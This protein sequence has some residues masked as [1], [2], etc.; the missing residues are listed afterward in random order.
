MGQRPFVWLTSALALTIF[1]L[2]N[3]LVQ[4]ALSGWRADFTEGK[5]FTL[6]DGTR[7]TLTDL[8]EPVELTFIYSRRVGQEFPA[9]RAYAQRVREL[10]QS[11]EAEAG[12]NLRLVE[13]DPTPFSEA[14]DEALSNGITAVQTDGDDP[15]YFG[16]VGR[17]AVD[18]DLV[19]PYLAPEREGTLEYDLTRLIARLDNPDPATIGILTDLPNFEG[20]GSEGGYFALQ[21]IARSYDIETIGSNF[22]SLP[23]RVDILLMAHVTDLSDEQ[24]YLIDQFLLDKGRALILVD[25]ASKAAAASGLVGEDG[26]ARSDLGALGEAW[27]LRLSQNAVADAPHALPVTVEENGRIVEQGQPLFIGVPTALMARDDLVTAPISRRINLGAPG[28]LQ[29]F[30]PDGL[31]FR[32][33]IRTDEAPSFIDAADASGEMLPRDVLRAYEAEDGQLVL[34]GRLSG[35]LP[36]AFPEG[37][38]PGEETADESGNGGGEEAAEVQ[39]V[40]PSLERSGP[41]LVSSR[42]PAEL[43][44]IAD[45]DLL[46]DGFYID[47]RSGAPVGGNANLILNAIDNLSGGA[48][49]LNLRSRTPD[50]RPMVRV[51]RLREAAEAEFFE[52]EAR[53]EARLARSLQRLE[54]L[55][56]IG[57]SGGFFSGDLEADLSTVERAELADL[58]QTVIETRTRLREIERNYRR[59]IDRLEGVLRLFNIWFGPVFV[60]LLGLA[61]WWHRERQAAG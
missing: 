10:L 33:L 53:L 16:L 27:G 28:A 15:L 42:R 8:A 60:L 22:T 40:A 1:V 39:D 30:P 57:A 35:R 61:V 31:T 18:D 44:I 34:A 50:L 20:N 14:E 29:A 48:E 12:R 36:S 41:H 45:A 32:A 7:Q 21:E 5:Q 47:P 55:R 11:F 38:P 17:N 37:P 4:P 46:D 58:R 56:A 52:E 59:S 43:I 25:P 19:I 49:L 13:I 54:E 26:A 2:A 6:S 23:K 24:A 51:D 9:I 3:T